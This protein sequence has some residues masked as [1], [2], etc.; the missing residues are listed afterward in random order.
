MALL[1][2]LLP[3]FELSF[4]NPAFRTDDLSDE[5]SVFGRDMVQVFAD[6]RDRRG[7]GVGAEMMWA[8]LHEIRVISWSPRNSHYRKD[9]DHSLRFPLGEFYSPASLKG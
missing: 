3:D 9:P 8:K 1:R 6:V 4:L 2:Q 7:S 5:C